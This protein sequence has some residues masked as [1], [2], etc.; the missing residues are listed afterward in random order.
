MSSQPYNT[1]RYDGYILTWVQY[2]WP[3]EDAYSTLSTSAII[4][5][6]HLTAHTHL[7]SFH[8]TAITLGPTATAMTCLKTQK[9]QRCFPW[10]CVHNK[11]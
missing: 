3:D 10:T 2:M 8:T 1:V 5:K 7:L 6:I 9:S 4:Q 11:L